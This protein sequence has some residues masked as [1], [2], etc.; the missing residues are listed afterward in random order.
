MNHKVSLEKLLI[1]NR[2]KSVDDRRIWPQVFQLI[3][4]H[5]KCKLYLSQNPC[6]TSDNNVFI[7]YHIPTDGGLLRPQFWTV[8][9]QKIL[10]KLFGFIYYT[11]SVHIFKFKLFI[12]CTP[13]SYTQDVYKRQSSHKVTHQNGLSLKCSDFCVT[14]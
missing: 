13:V 2:M 4:M 12:T 6:L 3:K 8:F 5:N 7:F 9:K 10:G 1:F 11:S 14:R